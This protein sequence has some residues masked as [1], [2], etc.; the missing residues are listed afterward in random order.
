M[1]KQESSSTDADYNNPWIYKG[2]IV[3]SEMLSNYAGFVYVIEDTN[4]RQLYIG[5]KFVS[6]YRK[7]KGKTRRQKSESDWKSYYS[8][9][10]GIKKQAKIDPKRFRREILHLCTGV[11]ETNFKEVEEQFKRD[12]LYSQHYLN[13]N[14]S[15]RWFKRNVMGRYSEN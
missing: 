10:E 1:T 5:K 15:G 3:T 6:S 9:H 13:D 12:V 11:G 2:E 7:V 4:T 14:I 8:S